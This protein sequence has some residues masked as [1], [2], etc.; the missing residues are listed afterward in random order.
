MKSKTAEFLELMQ[1]VTI[2]DQIN[3]YKL[4]D[5]IIY[6]DMMDSDQTN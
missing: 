5:S 1:E 3:L 6:G 2:R 4:L